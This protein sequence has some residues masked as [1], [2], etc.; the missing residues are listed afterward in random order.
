M[1]GGQSDANTSSATS[2]PT[3]SSSYEDPN[4]CPICL[5][6]I[7]QEAY[8]D[9]C[10][11]TFCYCCIASWTR[12]VSRQHSRSVSSIKCPLC[13]RENSSIIYGLS[14]NSFQ[15][16]YVNEALGSSFLTRA[17]KVRWQCYDIEPGVMD[18]KF[19]PLSFWKSRR[20]LQENRF[21]QAWLRREIQTL[22]QEEDVEIIMYHVLGLIES[23]FKRQPKGHHL[24]PP[25]EKRGEFKKL[26]SDAARSFLSTRTDRFVDELEL[27]LASGLTLDAYDKVCMEHLHVPASLVPSGGSAE[28]INVQDLRDP[29]LC[30]PHVDMD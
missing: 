19:D 1:D 27:F 21:L 4:R 15:R 7:K 3:A 13:K 29:R 24:Q 25:E 8:L 17:H 12:Y 18:H 28:D 5:E 16:H 30:F 22:L 6:A 20:Y 11:H 9:R 26:V 14:G 2:I 23:F 10:F